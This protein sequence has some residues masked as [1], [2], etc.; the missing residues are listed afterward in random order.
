MKEN[1][2]P[3]D[4]VETSWIMRNAKVP[5]VCAAM[6][7]IEGENFYKNYLLKVDFEGDFSYAKFS[8]KML[9]FRSIF[10]RKASTFQSSR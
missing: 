8:P 2:C 4:I 1:V 6:K 7:Q 9:K 5:E 3:E 10:T